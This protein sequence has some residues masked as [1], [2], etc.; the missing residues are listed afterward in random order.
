WALPRWPPTTAVTVEAPAAFAARLSVAE[1]MPPVVDVLIG[2]M[3]P[4][5]AVKATGVPSMTIPPAAL[6]TVTRTFT[7]LPQAAVPGAVTT[8]CWA[9]LVTLPAK[10]TFVMPSQT[11]QL[12]V[13]VVLPNTPRPEVVTP[14][15]T[16]QPLRPLNPSPPMP[17]M[18]LKPRLPVPR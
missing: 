18:P 4:C 17:P 8:T 7:V 3:V 11:P 6:R 2:E 16:P 12:L 14:L 1:A 10:L 9:Q 5:E 13:S 15:Q